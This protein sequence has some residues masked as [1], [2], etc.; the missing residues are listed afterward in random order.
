MSISNEILQNI[1][2]FDLERLTLGKFIYINLI[3]YINLILIN[4]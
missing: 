1:S 4:F 3:R 2:L